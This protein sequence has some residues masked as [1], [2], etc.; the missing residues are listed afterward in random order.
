MARNATS[1]LLICPEPSEMS[2]TMA[3]V[4]PRRRYERMRASAHSGRGFGDKVSTSVL[5]KS[6]ATASQ[7][8]LRPTAVARPP[9]PAATVA[10]AM[11]RPRRSWRRVEF[12][13]TRPALAALTA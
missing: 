8:R 3:L 11:P 4:R 1:T 13:A 10:P 7:P 9:T 5:K 12:A 6:L 2:D